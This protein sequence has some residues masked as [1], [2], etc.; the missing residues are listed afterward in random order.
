MPLQ[1]MIAMA[2]VIILIVVGILVMIA[3]FYRKVDQGRAL[4]INKVTKEPIVTFTGG[5]VLPIIHRSEIMDISVKTI[6]L[7]RRAHEGLICKD[8]IRAD[9]KV[10]FF[11]KVN[12]TVEDVLKVAANIGCQR[13]SDQHTLEE[14]FVAKFSEALKTVGK[15]LEFE[16]LYTQRDD[17]KDQIIEVIGKDLNGYVLEDAAI[18]FLEQTPIE[19]L[20]AENILDAQGIRKITELTAIQSVHTNELKQKQRME[21]GKQNLD[22]DEAVFR[23]EQQRADAE[24]KKAKEIAISQAREQNEA[25]RVQYDEQKKSEL[26]RQRAEEETKIGDENKQRAVEVAKK[27]REREIAVEQV[28]VRKAADL[29]ELTRERE[30][31]LK[32]FEKEK[33][34]EVERK[35]I[36][37]VIRTRVSVEKNVAE[38]EELIKDL[39]AQK[40]ATREKDVKIIGAEAAAQEKLIQSIKE[41]EAGEEVAKFDA[42]K[43]LTIAEAALEAADKEARA[44]MRLAEGIQAEEAASGLAKVRVRESEAVAIE[45][46]GLA[47][48][49]VALEKAQ[50]EAAGEEKKGLARV[51]IKQAD[52]EATKAQGTAQAESVRALKLAEAEGERERG[53][54]AVVVREADAAALEKHGLAEAVAIE[55]KLLAEAAGL[56]EK[57]AAMKA[58][59]EQSRAHEEFRLRLE[60]QKAIAVESIQAKVEMAKAQ[61]QV[62]AS[63]FNEARINIVGGDGAFFQRF[64]SAIGMGQTI[65]GVLDQSESLRTVLGGYL[66][67]EESLPADLKSILSGVTPEHLKN[68]SITALITR[69]MASAG[70]D[71]KG[72]LGALLEHA[73]IIEAKEVKN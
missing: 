30:V 53:M 7:E 19:H 57:A 8:N 73:K 12:K 63:A 2:L 51:K 72:K 37:D 50:A 43:R 22:A 13:A 15:R 27:A 54:A 3:K 60:Q 18:D 23:Y 10:T 11:V 40:E 29:E 58:L 68:L 31:E 36:A 42:R 62:L 26:A 46:T 71:L 25:L 9:I 44:K 65:D 33:A 64:V 61:A 48:A 70:P 24:A 56:A 69:L 21:I 66:N 38:Q 41:A 67:G 34:L 16:Q 45:K 47:E 28:R 59:D 5:V 55:K 35:E 4:I 52:A 49:K 39:R 20:D 6:N 32:R 17:F 14:L 1:V